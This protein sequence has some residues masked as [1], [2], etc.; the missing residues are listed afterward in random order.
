MA[1]TLC[2]NMHVRVLEYESWT[3]VAKKH[4][5]VYMYHPRG[6]HIHVRKKMTQGMAAYQYIADP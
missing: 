5:T 2:K 1:E 3:K 6:K 4:Q